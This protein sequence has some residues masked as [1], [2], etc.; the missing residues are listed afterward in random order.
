MPVIEASFKDLKKLI[1]KNLPRDEERLWDVLSYVKT[2]VD[3]LEGDTIKLDVGD[4]NRPDL[5]SIEGIARAF[6]RR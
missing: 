6:T 1:G 4:T 3:G 2:E 5:W